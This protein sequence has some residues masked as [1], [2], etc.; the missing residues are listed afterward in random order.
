MELVLL[1]TDILSELMKQ[2]DPVVR[3]RAEAYFREQSQVALTTLSC[4]QV[5]RWLREPPKTERLEQF[6]LL[7]A[8]QIVLEVN[9]AIVDRAADL[10]IEGR[11]NGRPREDIDLIIAS[12]ALVHDLTLVT[13]NVKHFQWIDGL[14]IDNWR[15]P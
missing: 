8:E 13:G 1:D 15:N 3:Q 7:L 10:W 9:L 2:R 11:A 4:Y 12:T 14:K 5:L 6:N